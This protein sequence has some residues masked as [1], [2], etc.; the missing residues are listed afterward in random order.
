MST[1]QLSGSP[2]SVLVQKPGGPREKLEYAPLT[3]LARGK[4]E[5]L[6]APVA[7]S[8]IDSFEDSLAA[9]DEAMIERQGGPE[10]VESM[11]KQLKAVSVNWQPNP[12]DPLAEALFLENLGRPE[13]DTRDYRA[14]FLAVVLGARTPALDDEEKCGEYLALLTKGQLRDIFQYALEVG[15]YAPK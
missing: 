2:K 7:K 6:Y 12:E 10:W 13:H 8:P 11:R 4:L 14:A 15:P 5:L 1:A 9:A 3:Y